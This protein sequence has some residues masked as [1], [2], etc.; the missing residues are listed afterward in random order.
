MKRKQKSGMVPY[1]K[2]LDEFGNVT[3]GPTKE[4]PIVPYKIPKPTEEQ[5]KFQKTAKKERKDVFE[6]LIDNFRTAMR[7][8]IADH[9]RKIAEGS[10]KRKSKTKKIIKSEVVYTKGKTYKSTKKYTPKFKSL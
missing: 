3:N 8:A 5:L 6:A 9:N 7:V 4:E 10:A 1:R 2:Q